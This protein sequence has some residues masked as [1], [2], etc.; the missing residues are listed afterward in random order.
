MGSGS[1]S[2][3][4]KSWGSLTSPTSVRRVQP[5][6]QGALAAGYYRRAIQRST[7][8]AN[9]LAQAG[10][11]VEESTAVNQIG[12][13]HLYLGEYPL[14]LENFMRALALDRQSGLAESE[15]AHLNN[16]G[17]VHF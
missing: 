6:F 16:I 9:A 14:A 17:H 15:V 7:D 8:A 13:G 4:S 10:A 5:I 12:L 1:L 11:L 2:W 3:C